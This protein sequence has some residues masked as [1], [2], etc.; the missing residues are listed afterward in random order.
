MILINM[1]IKKTKKENFETILKFVKESAETVFVVKDVSE[2]TDVSVPT[3][4]NIL[5]GLVELNKL[6]YTENCKVYV[7]LE[8]N[9]ND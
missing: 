5:D 8:N 3:V 6:E 2:R 4:K 7:K 1:V 9:N